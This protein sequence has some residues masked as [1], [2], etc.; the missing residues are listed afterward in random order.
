LNNKK[1]GWSVEAAEEPRGVI[2]KIIGPLGQKGVMGG[3]V[4]EIG[5]ARIKGG[6]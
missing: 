6:M 1:E 4:R 2:L 3:Q 5:W